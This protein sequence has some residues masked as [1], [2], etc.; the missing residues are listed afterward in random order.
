[1]LLRSYLGGKTEF[2]RDGIRGHNYAFGVDDEMG[3]W[4][5]FRQFWLVD[6]GQ[7]YHLESYFEDA[8]KICQQHD[9][10]T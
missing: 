8:K 5:I 9:A 2:P 10:L 7:I 6:N 3:S 4:R 1:M